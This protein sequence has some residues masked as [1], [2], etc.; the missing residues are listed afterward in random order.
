MRWRSGIGFSVMGIACL[1]R[2]ESA[3][4]QVSEP[5][6]N[7]LTVSIASNPE[8]AALSLEVSFDNELSNLFQQRME[9]VQCSGVGY[10]SEMVPTPLL[11]EKTNAKISQCIV[12]MVIGYLRRRREGSRFLIAVEGQCKARDCT[13]IGSWRR[14]VARLQRRIWDDFWPVHEERLN[15]TSCEIVFKVPRVRADFGLG[16]GLPTTD[17]CQLLDS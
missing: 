2:S 7:G 3:G 5:S 17:H 16:Q 14:D 6:F 10:T 15:S 11:K 4:Q 8:I 12:S 13:P 9:V 1:W